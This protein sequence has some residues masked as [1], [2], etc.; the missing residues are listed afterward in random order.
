MKNKLLLLLLLATSSISIAQT[1]LANKLKITA[2]TT[3]TTATKVNVQ[4]ADGTVNTMP[5]EA[6]G[7]VKS[8]TGTDGVTVANGSSTPVIG[9]SSISQLK[10]AGLVTDLGAKVDKITGKS[11]VS[12]SE[13]IRLSSV[14]N[15]DLGISSNT[16][17]WVSENG[18]NTT[19]ELGNKRKPYLTI[20]AA[21]DALPANGGVV[22]IG[23]GVFNSPA[24]TKV[25]NNV[26]FIG[27]KEPL[28]DAVIT[29]TSPTARPIYT[30]PTKL[31]GGTILRGQFSI[32]NK[33]N[34]SVHNLGV[35]VGSF[36]VDSFNSGVKRSGLVIASIDINKPNTNIHVGNVTVLGYEARTLEHCFLF[37][38]LADSQFRNLTSYYNVHGLVLKGRNLVLNG[39][40]GYSHGN[41]ALI[42]KSDTYA[43]TNC[44]VLK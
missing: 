27:A 35:D 31:I 9:I 36:W 43:P 39:Y 21:L 5:I 40:N 30:A 29:L 8:V 16:E 4:E 18:N 17:V 37:E 12:D 25:K 26:A 10:V 7:T 41:D 11:L 38:N 2:N 24:S 14:T 28:T 20:D 42:I 15:Q 3:S 34:V 23:I 6:F 1:T 44:H 22:N 33:N 13:I 32:L 19:A